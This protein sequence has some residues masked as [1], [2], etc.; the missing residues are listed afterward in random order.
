MSEPSA[1]LAFAIVAVASMSAIGAAFGDAAP[2]GGGAEPSLHLSWPLCTTS[3]DGFGYRT[4]PFTGR[5]A[6]HAGLDLK[7]DVGTPVHAARGGSVIAAEVRGPY[8]NMIE[9]D[10]G[11]GVKTRY[12]HLDALGVKAG[13]QIGEGDRIGLSG[14]SGRASEPH[15]HF[16][17]W[18]N[19][20]VWDPR[21]FLPAD[22]SARN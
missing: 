11:G 13:D 19:G 16:E 22:C 12:G 9:I 3:F 1:R 6:F 20:V 8:G 15:L 4:D 10:H 7:A 17:V 5:N 18:L 2:S 21:K 14:R